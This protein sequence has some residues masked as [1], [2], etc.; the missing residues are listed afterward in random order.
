MKMTL[1]FSGGS[2]EGS[3]T[4]DT[5]S[6]LIVGTYESGS[7]IELFKIYSTH[8]FRYLGDWDG[9]MIAGNSH[10]VLATWNRGRFEM[11]P[12]GEDTAVEFEEELQEYVE[13]MAFVQMN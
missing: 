13:P 5:G 2:I 12:E 6:F 7:A 11:W 3:G 4:D 8:T 10:Q 9:A 1:T